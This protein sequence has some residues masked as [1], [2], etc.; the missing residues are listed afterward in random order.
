MVVLS[1]L[2][3]ISNFKED[4][5]LR[6]KGLCLITCSFL[7]ENS[8]CPIVGHSNLKVGMREGMANNEKDI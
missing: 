5:F 4:I 8:P 2:L 1:R 3:L 6:D 7:E